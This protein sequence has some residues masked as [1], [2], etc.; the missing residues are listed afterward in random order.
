MAK[1]TWRVINAEIDIHQHEQ[2]AFLKVPP[3]S[4]F[5]EYGVFS[6]G[7]RA[8]QNFK[9]NLGD[10][11]ANPP[12]LSLVQD[13][14]RL[15][16]NYP[17]FINPTF[18]QYWSNLT[19]IHTTYDSP[20]CDL[21]GGDN[22]FLFCPA[23]RNLKAYSEA[24]IQST[25]IVKQSALGNR[26]VKLDEE[27]PI[28]AR[29]S[30]VD[31]IIYALLH[32]AAACGMMAQPA[33]GKVS[34]YVFLI[35]CMVKHLNETG[36]RE[37]MASDNTKERVRAHYL[38]NELERILQLFTKLITQFKIVD[39]ATRNNVVSSLPFKTALRRI[40][41]L[42]EFVYG[43]CQRELDGKGLVT[44]RRERTLE[45]EA[46]NQSAQAARRSYNQVSVLYA[47]PYIIHLNILALSVAPLHFCH[48]YI[49][50]N[51]IHTESSAGK[52][53]AFGTPKQPF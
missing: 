38:L 44:L 46:R 23:N 3:S 51:V 13:S 1:N 50:H 43:L 48:V 21:Q 16:R 49:L 37:S 42:P 28:V 30:N 32:K 24:I 52:P 53:G 40:M 19:P 34:Q 45:S 36:L 11:M 35:E 39:D 41:H 14:Y 22:L 9:A 47:V 10:S 20:E 31:D 26:R 27:V 6:V 7:P 29:C 18:F 12:R 17:P 4:A 25:S 33:E 2:A 15:A 5:C 8:V